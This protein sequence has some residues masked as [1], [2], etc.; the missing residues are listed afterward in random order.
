MENLQEVSTQ[1]KKNATNAL[2]ESVGSFFKELVQ[3][4]VISTIPEQ[5]FV[6]YFLDFFKS[7]MV[8]D[9]NNILGIKWVE[10]S[11]SPFNPVYVID[12]AGNY[13]YTVPPL[14]LK[15]D[16]VNQP[17]AGVNFSKIAATYELKNNR[18][19]TDA[20]NYINNQL[21]G[22]SDQIQSPDA[23]IVIKQWEYIFN[24]YAKPVVTEPTE[25]NR[26]IAKDTS[27]DNMINYD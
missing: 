1:L 14:V 4:P 25:A 9:S 21:S 3:V 5:V 2:T 12:G 19:S 10:L 7:G 6:E 22:L 13:L 23:N 24:R 11:K 20:A 17:I 16:L 15:P 8:N 18:L 27:M 26:M